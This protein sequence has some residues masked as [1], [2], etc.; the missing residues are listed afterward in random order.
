MSDSKAVPENGAAFLFTARRHRDILHYKGMPLYRHT[1]IG[2]V[3]LVSLG[4][5]M[6]FLAALAARMT[7]HPVFMARVVLAILLVSLLLF[8]NLTVIVDDE[9]IHLRF[10]IGLIRKTFQLADVKSAQPVRNSWL[11]GWGIHYGPGGWL[12]NVSGFGAVELQMRNGSHCR[13]GTDEP[14]KL[15]EAIQN[16]LAGRRA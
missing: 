4:G 2:W 5:A 1:Q 6:L 7:G 16:R 12:Y 15:C 9:S 8:A 13:I 10:G 3:M 14:E 11:Y